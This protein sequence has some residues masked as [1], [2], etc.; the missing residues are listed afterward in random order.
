MVPTPITAALIFAFT[1]VIGTVGSNTTDPVER[2]ALATR[3]V[4]PTGLA[5]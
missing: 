1:S 4:A 3:N 5:E 2:T